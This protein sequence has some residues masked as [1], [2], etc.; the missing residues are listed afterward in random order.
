M[1]VI[2]DSDFSYHA[3]PNPWYGFPSH[4]HMMATI[5]PVPH[6]HSKHKKGKWIMIEKLSPRK[7]FVFYL[8]M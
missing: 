5:L 1:N 3:V 6:L 4:H 8:E 2:K 7:D